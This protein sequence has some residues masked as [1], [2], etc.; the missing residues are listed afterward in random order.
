M[1][2]MKNLKYKVTSEYCISN[3]VLYFQVLK[4]N[5]TTFKTHIP[6]NKYM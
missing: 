5:I 3:F 2:R 4:P 6:Q 1:L